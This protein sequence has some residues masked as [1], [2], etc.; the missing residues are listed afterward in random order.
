MWTTPTIG[1]SWN[2]A[3]STDDMRPARRF[4]RHAHRRGV[5]FVEAIGVIIA[6]L[7][8]MISASYIWGVYLVRHEVAAEARYEVWSHALNGCDGASQNTSTK[9]IQGRTIRDQ[10]SGHV[11]AGSLTEKERDLV[12]AGQSS[13][14]EARGNIAYTKVTTPFLAGRV[15]PGMASQTI[16]VSREVHCNEKVRDGSISN[17]FGSIYSVVEH[18]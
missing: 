2:S 3:P 13:T 4:P 15:A 6:F 7:A 10:S 9:P 11:E 14:V 1:P 8:L 5:A 16:E 17:A 12:D 18:L